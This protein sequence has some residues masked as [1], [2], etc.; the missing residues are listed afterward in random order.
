MFYIIN[1]HHHH[2]SIKPT[3]TLIVEPEIRPTFGCFNPPAAQ[4]EVQQPK[5]FLETLG[6][7]LPPP[8]VG[9]QVAGLGLKL[10]KY[11]IWLVVWNMNLMTFHSVGNNHPNWLSYFSEGLK[12]PTSECLWCLSSGDTIISRSLWLWL[13]VIHIPSQLVNYC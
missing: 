7:P 4:T 3:K 12:P 9:A 10:G 5:K 2:T 13:G 8:A 11:F 1:H 6:R